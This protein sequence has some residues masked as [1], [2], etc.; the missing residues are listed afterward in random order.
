MTE[1]QKSVKDIMEAPISEE[2]RQA[3]LEE[4]VRSEVL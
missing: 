3:V 1:E 4:F 2:E